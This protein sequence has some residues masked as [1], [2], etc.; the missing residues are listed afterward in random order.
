MHQFQPGV[1]NRTE[2]K[3]RSLL[4]TATDTNIGVGVD[5]DADVNAGASAE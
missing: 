4:G 2:A 1:V 3:T 5:A